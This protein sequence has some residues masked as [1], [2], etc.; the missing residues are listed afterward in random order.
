MLFCLPLDSEVTFLKRVRRLA[1]EV[2]IGLLSCYLRQVGKKG[3]V[4][5]CLTIEYTKVV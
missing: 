5:F 2:P 4:A 3:S 1:S